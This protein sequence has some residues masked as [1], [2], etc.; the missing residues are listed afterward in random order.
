MNVTKIILTRCQV[1]HLKYTK[2]NFG[3]G[4]APDPA[5]S[6]PL[7]SLARFR[8]KGRGEGRKGVGVQSPI[9]TG[10]GLDAT[11]IVPYVCS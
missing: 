9:P 6:A 10:R 1:F 8:E 4:F 7:D 11:V 3:L 2:F 5:H